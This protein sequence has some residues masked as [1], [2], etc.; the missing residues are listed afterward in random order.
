MTANKNFK[1]RVRARMERT[2][3]TYTE[4]RDAVLKYEAHMKAAFAAG[5]VSEQGVTEI[6]SEF[7]VDQ[8]AEQRGKEPK[9]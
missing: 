3:E 4:A 8:R 6:T 2:G 7:D 9:P 1:R 5:T